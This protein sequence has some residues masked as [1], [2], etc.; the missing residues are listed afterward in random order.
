MEWTGKK[1]KGFF[2]LGKLKFYEQENKDVC[3][4]LGSKFVSKR[5]SGIQRAAYLSF[6]QE[7][8]QRGVGLLTTSLNRI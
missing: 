8:N 3:T 7:G 4:C 5:V 1:E 6:L 2:H